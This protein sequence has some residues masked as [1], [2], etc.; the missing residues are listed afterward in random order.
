MFFLF[1]HRCQAPANSVPF[2]SSRNVSPVLASRP[3]LEYESVT[4]RTV[5]AFKGR[6]EEHLFQGAGKFKLGVVGEREETPDGTCVDVGNVLGKQV[7]NVTG[8]FKDG[9]PHGLAK[10]RSRIC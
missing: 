3:C 1:A 9:R 6:V 8:N 4:T 7:V 10:V 5:F 2:N